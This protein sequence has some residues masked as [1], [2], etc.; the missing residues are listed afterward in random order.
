MGIFD[1][2]A[3]FKN[4]GTMEVQSYCFVKRDEDLMELLDTNPA[5]E[6]STADLIKKGYAGKRVYKYYSE[7]R[8]NEI[9]L[10]HEPTNP[11]D[12]NAVMI[13][14]KGKFFGYVNRDDAP[15][16]LKLLKKDAIAELKLK[17]SGGPYRRIFPNGQ[18][19]A[20]RYDFTTTLY[21]TLR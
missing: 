2:I 1:K 16:I 20:D 5:F 15:Q 4:A 17:H 11:N 18:S 6:L 8:N 19:T 13:L 21:I 7:Y 9:T 3:A 14:L 12:K 10:Q